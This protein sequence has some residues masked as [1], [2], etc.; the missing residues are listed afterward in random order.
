MSDKKSFSELFKTSWVKSSIKIGII[1][2]VIGIAA[3]FLLKI[4]NVGGSQFFFDVKAFVTEHGLLGVFLA[5]V[6]AGTIVPLGSPALVVAAAMLG[7]PRIPL[8]LVATCGFAIGM[9][10][11]YFLAYHLGRPFVLKKVSED[12]FEELKGMWDT[13]G[14]IVYVIFGFIPALPVELLSLLCGLFKTRLDVFLILSFL[15]RLMVFT[16]LAYFG[17]YISLWIGLT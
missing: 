11:N 10:A 14:W 12:K 5:T 15:P 16:V 3:L 9:L 13:W 2:T 4:F 7:A 17:E 6:L 8:V 1:F